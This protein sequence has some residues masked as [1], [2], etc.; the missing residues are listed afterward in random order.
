MAFP[1]ILY[2]SL[3]HDADTITASSTAAGYLDDDI[4]DWRAFKIWK[5]GTTVTPITIDFDMGVGNTADADSL[6]LINHNCLANTATVAVYYGA[7]SPP[8]NLALAAYT[9]TSDD[10]EYKELTAHAASRYW[11][12]TLAHAAAFPNAP[13]IGEALLGLRTALTEYLDP[14]FDPFMKQ[15]EVSGQRS[16]GGHYLG[17][18]LRGQTHRATISFGAAGMA[19]TFY[20]SDFNAFL[21]DHAY[22]R[23]PFVFVL[24]SADTDFGVARW[25]KVRD[26]DD[27]TRTAVGGVWSRLE[28]SLPVEEAW[29]ESA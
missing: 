4:A 10:V 24:D 11:R 25:I 7:A 5:S 29:M 14:G 3:C 13:Y 22:K 12:I 6:A 27:I 23:L 20:T 8:G 26:G 16:Q 15:V 9:P 2:D 28:L 17:A 19:R 21:D 18:I 1:K